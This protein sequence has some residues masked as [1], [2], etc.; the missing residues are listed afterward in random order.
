MKNNQ[1]RPTA[2]EK[3]VAADILSNEIYKR[4][5]LPVKEKT[6][7]IYFF[8][9]KECIKCKEPMYVKRD[10]NEETLIHCEPCIVDIKLER[11]GNN[12]ITIKGNRSTKV[13]RCNKCKTKHALRGFKPVKE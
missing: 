2:T 3:I 1:T 11:T 10:K 8:I 5:G 12:E 4:N 13:V 7:K 9:V 6:S